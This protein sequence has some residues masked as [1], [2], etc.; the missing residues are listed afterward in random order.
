MAQTLNLDWMD[1][2]ACK[3]LDIN[4]FY[5]SRNSPNPK[6]LEHLST[7]RRMCGGCPVLAECAEYG[8]KHE[9]YGFFGG[10]T[11]SERKTIRGRK[12]I[13]LERPEYMVLGK[14]P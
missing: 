14:K 12:N 1:Q 6:Y 13:P 10:L 11:E 9:K 5:T 2:A 8:I 3:G 7:L 4:F